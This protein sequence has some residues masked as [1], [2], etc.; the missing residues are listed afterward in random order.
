MGKKVTKTVEPT[1]IS[2]K[3]FKSRAK[4]VRAGNAK[5]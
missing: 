5:A 1:G 4:T 3:N 2:A